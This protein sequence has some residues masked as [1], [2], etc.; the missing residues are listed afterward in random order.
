MIRREREHADFPSYFPPLLQSSSRQVL[1]QKGQ[2]LFCCGDKAH[3]VYL[4]LAGEIQ[5]LRYAVN[6]AEVRLHHARPGE[7]FA[8]ASLFVDAYHCNAVCSET[9][10]LLEIQVEKLNECLRTDPDFAMS[11]ISALSSNLRGLRSRYERMSLKGA[12][13]RVMHYLATEGS[14]DGTVVL[15]QS[16]KAWAAE[17]GLS[18][19]V[20]YRTLAEME[21]Q[22]EIEKQGKIL[23]LTPIGL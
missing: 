15:T 11:W 7:Y 1:M 18:H 5:L 23:R 14:V 2:M 19:E 10:S 6:G 9:G 3:A 8:E 17:M 22:G 13:E 20:L 21:T 4:V 16:V 12:R